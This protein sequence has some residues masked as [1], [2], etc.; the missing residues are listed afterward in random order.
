[1]TVSTLEIRF[2]QKAIKLSINLPKSIFSPLRRTKIVHILLDQWQKSES[3]HCSEL[4]LPSA[5]WPGSDPAFQNLAPRSH[6]G[7]YCAELL[8]WLPPRQDFRRHVHSTSMTHILAGSD[9]GSFCTRVMLFQGFLVSDP[10]KWHVKIMKMLI[11]SWKIKQN[12]TH[13]ISWFSA[14][15]RT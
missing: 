8:L 9:A 12:R 6:E 3:R 1:M 5:T 10:R 4:S 2:S 7:Q 13:D 11:F 14:M 15:S